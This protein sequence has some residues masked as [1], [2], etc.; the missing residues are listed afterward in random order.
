VQ[1][2]IWEQHVVAA[3]RHHHA[4]PTGNDR[5]EKPVE[6]SGDVGGDDKPDTYPRPRVILDFPKRSTG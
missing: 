5:V 6:A 1:R 3:D 2:C 4:R